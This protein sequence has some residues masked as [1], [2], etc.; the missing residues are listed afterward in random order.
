LNARQY[1]QVLN[2]YAL[3]FGCAI[4]FTDHLSQLRVLSVRYNFVKMLEI[5]S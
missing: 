2:V 1:G 3:T 4:C 5:D